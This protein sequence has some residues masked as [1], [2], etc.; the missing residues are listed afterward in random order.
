MYLRTTFLPPKQPVVTARHKLN[1]N[2]SPFSTTQTCDFRLAG[3]T[4]ETGTRL[5]CGPSPAFRATDW[6]PTTSPSSAP[7]K[8]IWTANNSF[9]FL[10][11]ALLLRRFSITP[12]LTVVSGIP[13]TTTRAMAL[14]S[15]GE[16][17]GGTPG[18]W[19][20]GTRN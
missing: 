10:R 20:R 2:A 12:P 19:C 1:M 14:L 3:L 7:A 16:R 15:W 9:R 4:A 6:S 8:H 5:K 17:S 11:L 18:W 13:S